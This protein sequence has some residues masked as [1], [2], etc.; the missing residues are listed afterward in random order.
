M[1]FSELKIVVLRIL[2][3]FMVFKVLISNVNV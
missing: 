1:H 2:A 3:K